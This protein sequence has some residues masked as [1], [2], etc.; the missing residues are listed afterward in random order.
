M[1]P[2]QSLDRLT[3]RVITEMTP[4]LKEAEPDVVLVHGD[5]T[6]TFGAAISA[7][8]QGIAI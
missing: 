6:T 2:N 4:V 1:Q 3:A 8:Y 7:F 5:T